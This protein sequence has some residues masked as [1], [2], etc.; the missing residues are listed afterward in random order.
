[1]H[2]FNDWGQPCF[3]R[4]SKEIILSRTG[5]AG[6]KKKKRRIDHLLYDV[7]M[8]FQKGIKRTYLTNP[9]YKTGL[10]LT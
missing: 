3:Q 10:K 1:M 9:A 5:T 7:F 8:H 4:E 2:S 6:G